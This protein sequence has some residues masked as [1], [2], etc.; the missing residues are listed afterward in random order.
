LEAVL[1]GGYN[2]TTGVFTDPAWVPTGYPSPVWTLTAQP[3][4]NNVP[5]SASDKSVLI[6]GQY[7]SP[8]GLYM[9]PEQLPGGSIPPCNFEVFEWLA[10]GGQNGVVGQLSPWPGLVA[11][12]QAQMGP[13]IGAGGNMTVIS[14]TPVTLTGTASDPTGVAS[15]GWSQI[16]GPAVVLASGIR[17]PPV[18]PATSVKDIT[19]FSTAGITGTLTFTVTATSPSYNPLIPAAGG[20]STSSVTI[21]V[22]APPVAEIVNITSVDQRKLTRCDVT[23][24]SNHAP[25]G[26][27][28][29]TLYFYDA[30]KGVL[31]GTAPMTYRPATADYIVS[32]NGTGAN[33]TKL[34]VNSDQGGTA[35]L[36]NTSGAT[37]LPWKVR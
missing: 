37:Q 18:L 23:A 22:I 12:A 32:L 20:M 28:V 4:F 34:V 8:I 9:F 27:A 11:P 14:G 30:I 3:L 5:T 24:V 13:V 36:T 17:T 35:S 19:S 10:L 2:P 16:G 7:R 26:T 6:T 31:L 1:A 25:K 21:T 15:I 33:A 29:L